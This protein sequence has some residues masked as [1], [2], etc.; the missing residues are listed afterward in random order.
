MC[1]FSCGA[2][3]CGDQINAID[4]KSFEGMS[5][6]EANAILRSCIGDFCRIEVTPSNLILDPSNDLR[7]SSISHRTLMNENNRQAFYR[8][9]VGHSLSANSNTNNTNWSMRT[10]YQNI[11]KKSMNKTRHNSISRSNLTRKKLQRT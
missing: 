8:Q 1:S 10:N 6:I 11:P 3:H 7:S 9:P 5:L 2:L 4:Q